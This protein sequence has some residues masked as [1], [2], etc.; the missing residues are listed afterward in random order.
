MNH[1]ISKVLRCVTFAVVLPLCHCRTTRSNATLE[2][3]DPVP[4][5]DLAPQFFF[6]WGSVASNNSLL[7]GA[8]YQ[9][10]FG[11]DASNIP[12]SRSEGQI[13]DAL[14]NSIHSYYHGHDAAG[15]GLYVSSGFAD[16][17]SYGNSLVVIEM[18]SSTTAFD[19]YNR[20]FKAKSDLAWSN[21]TQSQLPYIVRYV[22]VGPP[23]WYVIPRAPTGADQ[24]RMLI[25][26]PDADDPARVA[27][28]LTAKGSVHD[29]LAF[30][31]GYDPSFDLAGDTTVAPSRQFVDR[32]FWDEGYKI[33]ARLDLAQVADSDIDFI[34]QIV[35]YYL[36][37]IPTAPTTETLLQ[38]YARNV[39]TNGKVGNGFNQIAPAIAAQIPAS[40]ISLTLEN[41][42]DGS[43]PSASLVAVK[44]LSPSP[45]DPATMSSFASL[46]G[47][48]EQ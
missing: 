28:T 18:Q 2:D 46:G 20:N 23:F 40:A 12:T 1:S 16:T 26:A 27:S 33:I 14:I 25:Y 8:G 35:G 5:T 42:L 38:K 48:P 4:T 37:L 7:Q 32:L 39:R 9:G 44:D 3:A 10:T 34:E 24:G 6:H 29:T 21:G 15:S 45:F 36:Q 41:I 11:F 47:K 43:A 17:R 30:L 31:A 19:S 13:T 22:E